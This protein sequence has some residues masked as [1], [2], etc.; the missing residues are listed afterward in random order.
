MCMHRR[1]RD[2][3]LLLML[4]AWLVGCGSAERYCID[5]PVHAV[6]GPD[7]D[8]MQRDWLNLI[9]EGTL[10]TGHLPL[11]DDDIRAIRQAMRDRW[12]ADADD[13]LDL[14]RWLVDFDHYIPGKVMVWL[15]F[16]PDHNRSMQFIV[17]HTADGWQVVAIWLGYV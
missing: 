12:R 10:P 6:P 17:Y 5:L 8:L 2:S 14:S 11:H 15:T 16:K 9:Y 7:V 1:P 3:I 4:L 13:D